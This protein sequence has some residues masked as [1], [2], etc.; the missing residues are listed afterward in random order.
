M[1]EQWSFKAFKEKSIHTFNIT[2]NNIKYYSA[3]EEFIK[4]WSLWLRKKI[5]DT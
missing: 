3:V 1:R 4:E 5:C 2:L